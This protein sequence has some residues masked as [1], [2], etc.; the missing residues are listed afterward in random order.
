MASG[1]DGIASRNFFPGFSELSVEAGGVA[2]RGV[3]GGS[4]PPVLLLHG[5]PQTHLAW[6]HVAPRLARSFTVVAPDLPG[7]GESRT[8]SDHP[9]W[10]KRRVADSLVALMAKL[11]HRRFDIVGHDRGARAGYRLALDHPEQVTHLA[12]L[13]VIPTLDAWDLVDEKF[14]HANFHWFFLAQPFDLPEKLLSA[15]PQAFI[16]SA[17]A[18]MAGGLDNLEPTVLEAYRRAFHNPDVRHA[19]CE[20]YRAAAQEDRAC[21]AADRATGKK[22]RC[23]VLMLWSQGRAGPSPL[24]IWRR[25][26]DDVRGAPIRGGHLQPEESPEEVVAELLPFLLETESNSAA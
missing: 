11:G 18:H 14:G 22:L 16:D 4:G 12:S 9:R 7:Y 26:A 5:Y 23:P 24:D 8:D 19:M 20:D 25:W 3:T 13:T 6:R 21:D 1:I 2:F 15:S 17:L 10:T